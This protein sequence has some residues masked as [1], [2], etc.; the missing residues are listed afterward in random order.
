MGTENPIRR[1]PI[2]SEGLSSSFQTDWDTTVQ[3]IIINESAM[4]NGHDNSDNIEDP[5]HIIS[6]SSHQKNGYS[7]RQRQAPTSMQV[8]DEGEIDK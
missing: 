1:S 7:P 6:P 2:T 4:Y 8:P 3:T 5:S